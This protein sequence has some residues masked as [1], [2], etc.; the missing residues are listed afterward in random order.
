[1]N[2]SADARQRIARVIQHDD[3]PVTP[4]GQLEPMIGTAVP[5]QVRLK[6]LPAPVADELKGYQGAQYTVT[7]NKLLVVDAG[8]G[9][10]V[11]IVPDMGIQ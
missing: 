2:L 5:R 11:A 4:N 10:V 9:R 7:N 8:A 6:P 1:L 3:P